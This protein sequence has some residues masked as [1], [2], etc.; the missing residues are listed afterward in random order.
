MSDSPPIL[1]SQFLLIVKVGIIIVLTK[2]QIISFFILLTHSFFVPGTNLGYH[3]FNMSLHLFIVYLYQC[4][5]INIYFILSYYPI[6]I[7]FV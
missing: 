4:R 6:N 5:I 2:L 3:A 7:I 1:F